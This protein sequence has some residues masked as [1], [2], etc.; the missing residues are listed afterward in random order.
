MS[1]AD[2]AKLNGIATSAN[3]YIHPT[4][5][6]HG[7]DLYKVSVSNE[8]HVISAALV[9]KADITALGI[10][11]Q[12]TTYSAA[13]TSAAGLMSAEDK[14]KLD[15]I[16]TSANAYVYAAY[17]AVS[18]SAAAELVDMSSLCDGGVMIVTID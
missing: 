8:G 7:N 4:Y 1:P 13:T 5:G 3:Y 12:D 10:P 17:S 18:T 14:A 6:A 2:K 15:G 16:A 11:A 9:K